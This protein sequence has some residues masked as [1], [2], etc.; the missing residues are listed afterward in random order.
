MAKRYSKNALE[1][2]AVMNIASA[3]L[4]VRKFDDVVSKAVNITSDKKVLNRKRKLLLKIDSRLQDIIS[5][6][7]SVLSDMSNDD[8]LRLRKYSDPR[9]IA[10]IPELTT[11]PETLALN[12]LYLEF[13]DLPDSKLDERLKCL[14]EIDYMS[15]IEYISEEVG[16]ESDVSEDMYVL[17]D[18]LILKIKK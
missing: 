10:T 6:C 14:T 15:L 1:H 4:Q 3:I 2:L 7:H 8:L 16:L 9:V 17:A 12:L 18:S 13:N 5:M 11:N